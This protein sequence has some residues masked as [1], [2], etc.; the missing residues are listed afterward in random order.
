MNLNIINIVALVGKANKWQ[1]FKVLYELVGWAGV[2]S[3]INLYFAFSLCWKLVDW[4]FEVC[5]DFGM[6]FFFP[7]F[8][9]SSSTCMRINGN[10]I[11]VHHRF[12]R[13]KCSR[14]VAVNTSETGD[15]DALDYFPEAS[16]SRAQSLCNFIYFLVSCFCLFL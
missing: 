15:T 8:L 4:T 10:V 12:A 7:L 14:L 9:S 2:V 6:C 13:R 5:S 3:N 1:N 16:S 11:E